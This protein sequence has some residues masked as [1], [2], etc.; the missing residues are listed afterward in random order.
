[1]PARVGY[2]VIGGEGAFVIGGL[3]AALT[4]ISLQGLN[5][6]VVL[7]AMLLT[8]ALCGGLWILAV[9]ALRT[10]RQVNETISSLLLNYIAIAILNFLVVGILKDPATLNN[11]STA[12][13][14]D[15]NMLTSIGETSI[16]WGI[17]MVYRPA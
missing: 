10:F 3:M 16:H 8:G 17:F 13:I 5:A 2:I 1:M 11:P 9:G 12:S 14:G 4:G 7:T 6:Y 15:D